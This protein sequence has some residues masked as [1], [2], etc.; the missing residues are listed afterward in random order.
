MKAVVKAPFAAGLPLAYCWHLRP[1]G[2]CSSERFQPHKIYIECLLWSMNEAVL[3][4]C[5]QDHP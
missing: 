2:A 1:G 5:P 4:R 3:G